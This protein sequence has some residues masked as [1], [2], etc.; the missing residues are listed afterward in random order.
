MTVSDMVVK[1]KTPYGTKLLVNG[2]LIGWENKTING[3]VLVSFIGHSDR[4]KKVQS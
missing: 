1:E 4:Y 2:V 3:G